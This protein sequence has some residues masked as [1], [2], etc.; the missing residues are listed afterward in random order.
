MATTIYLIRHGESLGNLEKRFLGHSDWDLTEKGKKQ[1]EF[2]AGYF[3]NI[4]VDAIYSSDLLRAHDTAVPHA[5]LRGLTVIDSEGLREVNIGEWEGKLVSDLKRDHYEEFV[6]K[7]Q[8]GFGTFTFPGGDNVMASATRF[9]NEV[10]RIAREHQGGC[11]LIAAHAAVIRAFW[12]MT[13][14]IA[15]EN[16][17]GAYPYPT[18]ASYSTLYFDG[19]KFTPIEYSFD[20]HMTEYSEPIQ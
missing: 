12:C 5:E 9:Y 3:E 7:W 1:A 10:L 13:C 4:K 2:A 16:M 11:V 14:N 18:N 20:K 17:A 15:P 8:Q 6:I 19:E